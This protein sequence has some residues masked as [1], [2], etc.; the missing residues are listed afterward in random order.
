MA[1]PSRGPRL[2]PAAASAGASA[3][4]ALMEAALRWSRPPSRS[5]VLAARRRLGADQGDPGAQPRPVHEEPGALRR[6]GRR[7]RATP[8][9]ARSCSSALAAAMALP[10]GVLVA[11]YVSEF[12]RPRVARWIRAGARRAERA[13]LDRDRHLRLRPARRPASARTRFIASIA[14]GDHHAAAHLAVDAGGARA[15]AAATLREAS[16]ALGVRKWR[17]VLQ[18]RPA[19]DARRDPDR[20]DARGRPRGRRDRADP[21]HLVALH[22]RGLGRPAHAAGDV[23][24]TIFTYSEAPD[25]NL[26]DQ[27]WAAAF[28]LI[29]FVL[30]TSLR[31]ARYLLAPQ[32]PQA[33]ARLVTR[34]RSPGLSPRVHH[35]PGSRA[36]ERHWPQSTRERT[37]QKLCPSL[38]LA[39]AALA[40]PRSRSP[41]RADRRNAHRR[42][43][44]LRLPAGLAVA[45]DY[46]A[47]TGTQIATARSAPA[48]GIAA[49][50]ARTGRLRRQRRAALARPVR[51]RATAA[52]RSRGR[53]PRRRSSTTSRTS[54]TTCR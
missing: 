5:R 48:R 44:P 52:S 23:P 29:M 35:G 46:R 54:R 16:Q 51:R 42:G 28:V 40:R 8:S 15:R 45:A 36:A 50:T 19:D 20:R 31:L 18:R 43:Q 25:P 49:I 6:D 30:V 11:I 27:A 13:P 39:L 4:T 7:D 17:T 53:C 21:L 34:D 12:A 37:M 41:G 14:L 2:S 24:F 9:S 1:R 32:P 26:H 33:R 38:A 22:E 3:S 10:V 47:K